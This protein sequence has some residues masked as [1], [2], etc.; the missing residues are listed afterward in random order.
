M[1]PGGLQPP[2][3]N[4]PRLRRALGAVSST[5]C[6][7]LLRAIGVGYTVEY[8]GRFGFDPQKLPRNLSLALGTASATPMQ[9]TSA[10]A[11]YANGG[12]RIEPHFTARASRTSNR[13][14]LSRQPSPPRGRTGSPGARAAPQVLSPE[15]NFPVTS[16]MRDV[17]RG[18]YRQGRAR[19]WAQSGPRYKTG[20]N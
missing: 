2:V 17:I 16:M 18:G 8:L 10:F 13:K 5:W 7:C 19:T 14:V 11:V 20:T 3:R 4:S 12:Y 1:A 6:R 9:M 15:I